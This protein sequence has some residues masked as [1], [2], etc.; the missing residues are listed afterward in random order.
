MTLRV[1]KLLN[2]TTWS[3]NTN[4]CS[5]FLEAA[6]ALMDLSERLLFWK[7]QYSKHDNI[8]CVY[9]D[10]FSI[11][12]S[13]VILLYF[14]VRETDFRVFFSYPAHRL[15]LVKKYSVFRGNHRL[16]VKVGCFFKKVIMPQCA[17][18][19][20]VLCNSNSWHTTAVHCAESAQEV[21]LYP[22]FLI[23]YW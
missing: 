2:N 7:E 19:N 11:N 14:Y 16:A 6:G 10:K 17:I 22:V 5:P 1:R 13:Y 23:M 15:H 8:T 9:G 21:W 18:V 12:T 3:S 20:P 4:K